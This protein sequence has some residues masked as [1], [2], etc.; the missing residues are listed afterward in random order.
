MN[1]PL[2]GE[3]MQRQLLRTLMASLLLAAAW[4]A[5]AGGQPQW[6]PVVTD[7]Q[8]SYYV[9]SANIQ[10]QGVVRTFWSLRDYKTVQATYDG[11]AYRS[12]LLKI[13]LDCASQEAT[14]LEIT[15]FTGKMLSGDKAQRESDFHNAQPI[16]ANTPISRFAQRLCK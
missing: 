1:A 14:A 8:S 16:Q 4:P 7:A 15:Y 9:D 2:S 5:Q 11:K 6:D 10:R 12:T 13:E 3:H